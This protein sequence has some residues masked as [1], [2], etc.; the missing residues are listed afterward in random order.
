[1][2]HRQLSV[3]EVK[4]KLKAPIEATPPPMVSA[5]RQIAANSSAISIS[6]S[7]AKAKLPD[8]ERGLPASRRGE[9]PVA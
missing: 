1:M 7:R 4:I 2:T 8:P 9:C 3:V 6:T 5:L